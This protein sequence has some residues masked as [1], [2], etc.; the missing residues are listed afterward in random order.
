MAS[1]ARARLAAIAIACVLACL[2]AP[3]VPTYAAQRVLPVDEYR[4][5]V[6]AAIDD[7]DAARDRPMDSR[8][9]SELAADVNTLLPATLPVETD[10]D[11]VVADNSI[12]RTLVSRL[13]A[14]KNPGDRADIADEM[15][16]H[17]VSLSSSLGTP[18]AAVPEDPEALREIIAAQRVP[19]GSTLT[20]IVGKIAE[21]LLD[22]L[23]KWWESAGGSPETVSILSTGMVV[24]LAV[25]LV[26]LGWV[27]VRAL[28][29]A[30]A[31]TAAPETVRPAAPGPVVAAAEG[32]P[33]DAL[34]YADGLAASGQMREA[35]RALFGGAARALV[36]AGAVVQTRTRTDTELLAEVRANVPHAHGALAELA[37]AFEVAYYGHVEPDTERYGEARAAY[38]AVLGALRVGG[39]DAS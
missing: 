29:R 8:T 15:R 13:D 28:L 5:R 31:A 38:E 24:L 27:L 4:S 10:R 14:A 9:A 16:R 12:L 21:R 18:G 17:L 19:S 30:R 25:L 33:A 34:A 2:L 7:I 26:F 36:E 22:I 6:D 1:R 37:N 35:V 23:Q 39:G 11:T 20:E 32:L 3:A